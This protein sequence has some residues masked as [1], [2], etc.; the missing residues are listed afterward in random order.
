[1]SKS[2]KVSLCPLRCNSSS[3]QDAHQEFP[4]PWTVCGLLTYH[5]LTPASL[6]LQKVSGHQNLH[7]TNTWP[8]SRFPET[9]P[10]WLV[11]AVSRITVW[12]GGDWTHI[13]TKSL[14]LPVC[15]PA[16]LRGSYQAS[17]HTRLLDTR[18]GASEGG[19]K[20]SWRQRDTS[21]TT[22]KWL[23]MFTKL[24]VEPRPCGWSSLHT[25]FREEISSALLVFELCLSPSSLGTECSPQSC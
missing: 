20:W 15:S 18:S 25:G 11:T 5:H 9:S 23:L 19:R 17:E 16:V 8:A 14:H 3:W 12:R 1:M 7:S 22:A 21:Q 6:E 4:F 24:W 10:S 2:Q 13:S